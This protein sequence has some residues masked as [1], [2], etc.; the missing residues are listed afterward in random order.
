MKP[1]DVLDL[2]AGDL[3]GS[4]GSARALERAQL[5]CDLR[6]LAI[7]RTPRPIFDYVDGGADEE[8]SLSRNRAAYLDWDLIPA[9]PN[10]VSE[11]ST[12]VMLLGERVSL[13]LVCGPTGYTR[14]MH[15]DGELG[16]A[17]A[18]AGAGVP[19]A[20]STLAST[21]LED[22]AA[23]GHPNLWFQLYM[24]RDRELSYALIDRAWAAGYR[25]LEVCVDVPVSGLRIRDVR[26]GL[27]IPPA[28]TGAALLGF[29][30]KPRY[31]IGALMHP[32]VKFANAP[33]RLA[34]EDAMTVSNTAAQFDPSLTWRDIT[35][36]R[37]RWE[38]KLIVKGPMTPVT[39]QAAIDAG[40]DG[41]HLSNHGG[42]Q[43]DRVQPPLLQLPAVREAV[44]ARPTLL[45]DSGIRH[46][47]DLAI[48]IALGAD[49]GAIGRAYL[50]G[51]MAGGQRGVEIALRILG[52]EFGRALTL[53]G[54]SSVAELRER[55]SELVSRRS[56]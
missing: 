56:R 23:S 14:M 25:T 54:V 20:L 16:V 19:Y 15:P 34:N 39:A 47:T 11:V 12:D 30:R 41:L 35:G 9:G 32:S 27:T 40:A 18:A 10:D 42:R 1:N 4:A 53:L 6:A 46:G 43:L 8:L 7:K 50:Y 55:G 17:A 44:G 2:L 28:L 45:V 52:D 48:A 22:V 26:N 38:G 49:A 3:F 24:M 21:S 37:G 31:W 5:I 33:G 13:P 36:L 51:L 29:I